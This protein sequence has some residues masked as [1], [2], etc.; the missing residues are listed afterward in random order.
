MNKILIITKVILL[1][2]DN[3]LDLHS[4]KNILIDW[5][6]LNHF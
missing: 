2:N 3:N 1:N 5:I 4:S 6:N